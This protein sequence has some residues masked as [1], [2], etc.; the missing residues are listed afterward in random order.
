ME[1]ERTPFS[2]TDPKMTG[3]SEKIYYWWYVIPA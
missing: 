2:G 3:N 1:N